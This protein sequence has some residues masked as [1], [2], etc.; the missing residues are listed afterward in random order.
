MKGRREGF[1]AFCSRLQEGD[2]VPADIRITSCFNL[3][4]D[5]AAL[6]GECEAQERMVELQQEAGGHGGDGKRHI[7]AIE[8]Q[9]LMFYGESRVAWGLT[10]LGVRF[11]RLGSKT[12][13]C[14]W[15]VALRGA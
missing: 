8:A 3:K 12:L 9:N 11:I 15:S 6:T 2:Q 5:N 7:P 14:V 13:S 1:D 10:S 4:V